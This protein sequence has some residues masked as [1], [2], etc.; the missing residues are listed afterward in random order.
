MTTAKTD[1]NPYSV[2]LMLTSDHNFFYAKS[3]NGW[4][5]YGVLLTGEN[6]AICSCPAGDNGVACKHRQSALMRFPYITPTEGG[7]AELLNRAA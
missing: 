6:A 4:D 2:I 1:F 3:S 7:L 5:V